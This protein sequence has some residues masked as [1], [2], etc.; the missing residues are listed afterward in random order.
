[1]SPRPN[2]RINFLGHNQLFL[3]LDVM[4]GKLVTPQLVASLEVS[5]PMI[6]NDDLYDFKLEA[7]I[8]CF[9]RERRRGCML[10]SAC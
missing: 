4:V 6:K 7:R 10:S 2:S 1:M 9:F 5:A 8:G 3:P